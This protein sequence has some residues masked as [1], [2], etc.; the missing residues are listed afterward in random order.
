ME[1]VRRG[2]AI[3]QPSQQ[4]VFLPPTPETMQMLQRLGSRQAVSVAS[5]HG[6]PAVSLQVLSGTCTQPSILLSEASV[7]KEKVSLI[8]L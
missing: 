4:P 1:A 8:Y 6:S 7:P 5:S 2:M 3:R